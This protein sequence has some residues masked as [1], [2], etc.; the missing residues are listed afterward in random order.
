MFISDV[1]PAPDGPKIA[2]S[3]PDLKE[4]LIWCK[5]VFNFL[6]K[7]TKILVSFL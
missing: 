7:Q 1:F 5:I 4:P 6:P 3:W 2:V